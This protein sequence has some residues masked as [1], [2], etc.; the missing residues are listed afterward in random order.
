MAEIERVDI[1]KLTIST[2]QFELI[3]EALRKAGEEMVMSTSDKDAEA[4][5]LARILHGL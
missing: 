3:K 5:E 2:Y 4:V 1:V